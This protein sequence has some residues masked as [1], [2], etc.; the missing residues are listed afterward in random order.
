MDKTSLFLIFQSILVGFAFVS[1]AQFIW[2]AVA[3]D[4]YAK[5]LSK[6]ARNMYLSFCC[7]NVNSFG[8]KWG[9]W[10]CGLQ[11]GPLNN[12]NRNI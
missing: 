1:Y 7:K 11:N 9:W 2:H 3:E 6:Y 12:T 4:V 5:Q 8:E 10:G